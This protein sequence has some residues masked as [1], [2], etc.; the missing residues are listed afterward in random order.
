MFA[1]ERADEKGNS[2]YDEFL[3]LR[4]KIRRSLG[5][6]DALVDL[7]AAIGLAAGARGARALNRACHCDR[8]RPVAASRPT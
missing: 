8:L 4:Y 1:E 3:E 7:R 6:A 5:D 2:R